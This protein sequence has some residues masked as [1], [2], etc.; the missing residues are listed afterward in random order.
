MQDFGKEVYDHKMRDLGDAI[1][2][3]N[4]EALITEIGKEIRQL[5]KDDRLDDLRAIGYYSLHKGIGDNGQPG[6]ANRQLIVGDFSHIMVALLLGI[7]E[8]LNMPG[9]EYPPSFPMF[10]RKSLEAYQL[11]S[12]TIDGMD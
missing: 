9:A 11:M 10:I 3:E 6:Y 4:I 2:E 5:V 7:E 1:T 12:Q 8:A